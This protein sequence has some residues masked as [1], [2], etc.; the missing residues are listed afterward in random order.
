MPEIVERIPDCRLLVVGSFGDDKQDYLDL[1]ENKKVGN[2]IYLKDTYTPDNEVEK[3][4][5][6]TDL[7]V[8]PYE[9]A[10]QSGIVQISFG[11]EKTVLVTNVG[12]LPDVV[13]NMKTGYVV[14]SG[15]D[16]EISDAVI[17][18]FVNNRS[19]SFSQE[20]KNN[21]QKFSWEQMVKS[22]NSLV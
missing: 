20:I 12:G 10:T 13:D 15:N 1:I 21:A 5:A 14:N 9:D 7:V 11:F 2:Y 16:S 22:I 18:F 4:F 3:Y 8:L 19:N 17:D 6:A